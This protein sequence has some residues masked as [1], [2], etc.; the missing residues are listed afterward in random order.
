MTDIKKHNFLP[1]DEKLQKTCN[2]L[3]LVDPIILLVG[4][5]NGRDLS[6]SSLLYQWILQHEEENGG[7]PP[8]EFE[9]LE[10]VE[11][12]KDYARFLPIPNSQM[13]TAQRTLAEYMH[14]KKKS[15]EITDNTSIVESK[16][17]STRE[18]RRFKRTFNKEF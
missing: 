7:E 14:N 13:L 10:L 4:F 12:I 5:A 2:D 3:G 16:P 6:K 18:I 1:L 11:L 9:W 15:V 17:L 8:D